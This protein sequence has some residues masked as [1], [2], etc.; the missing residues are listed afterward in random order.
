M[1][2]TNQPESAQKMDV[3]GGDLDVD[4]MMDTI[5][6]HSREFTIGAVVV[7]ALAAGLLLWRQSSLQKEARA[8]KALGDATIEFQSGNRPLALADLGKAVDRYVDTRAGVE[9][10]MIAAQIDFEDKKWDDGIKVLEAAKKSSVISQYAGPVDGL[11]GGALT[12]QK[13]YDEAVKRYL[14]AADESE[15]QAMKDVYQA[16]AARVLALAGKKDEAR[17]IWESIASRPDSPTA[18][19]AKVRLG[20]LGAVPAKN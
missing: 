15:Y 13:K 20:E 10:A 18:G 17:K 5:R 6:A 2:K 11:I 9:A 8:E 16:D 19:E 12:D 14:A 1:T 7:I 4:N 3:G